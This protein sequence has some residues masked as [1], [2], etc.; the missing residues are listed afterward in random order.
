M[1]DN[2]TQ[3]TKAYIHSFLNEKISVRPLP[4]DL[5]KSTPFVLK[6]NYSCF[7]SAIMEKKVVLCYPKDEKTTTPSKVHRHLEMLESMTQ[8]PAILVL[9]EVPSYNI[10]R[11]I[12]Q[13]VNFIINGKQ[14]FVPSLL[15]DLRKLPTKDRDIKEQG[16]SR[17]GNICGRAYYFCDRTEIMG[18]L[19]PKCVSESETASWTAAS[20][21]YE[22]SFFGFNEQDM[23]DERKKLDKAIRETKKIKEMSEEEKRNYYEDFDD[24]I[25]MLG[26]PIDG[27][28]LEYDENTVIREMITTHISIYRIVSEVYNELNDKLLSTT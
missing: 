14:M 16:Y 1:T 8:H 23:L 21:L 7:S 24:F 11:L 12:D 18:Y 19:V 2:R 10:K 5:Q 15:M 3:A 27:D 22:I 26:E 4:M 28:D 25:K 17:P 13:R 20:I 6:S 9:T